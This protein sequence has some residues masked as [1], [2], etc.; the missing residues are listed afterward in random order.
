MPVTGQTRLRI[1]L[2][3]LLVV[4]RLLMGSMWLLT[5]WSWVTRPDAASS[6][7]DAIELSL[8]SG[9]PFPFYAPFL[10]HVVLPNSEVFAFLVAWGEFLT[11]V[12]PSSGRRLVSGRV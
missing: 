12:S 4:G 5:G 11:G 2:R 1:A 6:L 3:W 7:A 8:A 10:E 9:R